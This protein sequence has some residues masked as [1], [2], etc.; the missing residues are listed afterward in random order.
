MYKYTL[1]RERVNGVADNVLT[2]SPEDAVRFLRSINLHEEEQ[3]CLITLVLGSRNRIRGYYN[4]TRGLVN[5]TH[6]HAREIFRYAI[7]NN[8]T[9]IIMAHNHPSGEPEPSAKDILLT[10]DIR[11]ASKIL[12]IPL[13]DHVIIGDNK[14]YSFAEEGML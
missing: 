12:G 9:A 14:Y 5:E 3:E 6:G 1:N 10:G 13:I 11:K 7:I 2:S 8:A 4:V